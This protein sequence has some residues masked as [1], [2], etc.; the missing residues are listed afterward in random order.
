M[1]TKASSKPAAILEKLAGK[2]LAHRVFDNHGSNEGRRRLHMPLI[3]P[4]DTY[5]RLAT[6]TEKKI[7]TDLKS[8]D[9][10]NVRADIFGY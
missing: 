6:E 4:G 8:D 2:A 5:S 10:V 7:L 1:A 9:T 3:K